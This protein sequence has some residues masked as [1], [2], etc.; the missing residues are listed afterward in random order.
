M[1]A[2][3]PILGSC[4]NSLSCS[5]SADL[6]AIL[7]LHHPSDRRTLAETRLLMVAIVYAETRNHTRGVYLLGIYL[8]KVC[9]VACCSRQCGG[10]CRLPCCPG[11]GQQVRRGWPRAAALAR[12]LPDVLEFWLILPT[13]VLSV[14][15]KIQ[16]LLMIPDWSTRHL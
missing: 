8:Q 16:G 13:H 11:F 1:A 6:H 9:E 12:T 15:Y 4:D 10:A 14:R 2:K 3:Y 5:S 7:L